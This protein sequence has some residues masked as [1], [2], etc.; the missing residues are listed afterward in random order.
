MGGALS[1]TKNPGLKLLA[2]DLSLLPDISCEAFTQQF[3][4]R[5]RGKKENARPNSLPTYLHQEQIDSQP[6][7]TVVVSAQGKL[8]PR[9][10][11]T[12]M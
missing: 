6:I 8:E 3:S 2:A 7:Y 10:V 4:T 12:Q 1:R 5:S 11:A 9:S